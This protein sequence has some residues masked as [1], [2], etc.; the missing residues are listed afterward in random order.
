MVKKEKIENEKVAGI[1]T[2][3]LVG[4]IWY[5]ADEKMNKSN[6]VKFHTKQAINFF[7]IMIVTSLV[8][9]FIIWVPIIG[10]II[11]WAIQIAFLV[12]WIIGIINSVNF[13]K[14]EIPIIGSF[15]EKYLT[16]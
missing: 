6:F 13:T 14:K 7:I 1:L 2:Y 5:F 11:V 8:I 15:A 10:W 12:L 4:I 9:S 3:F 16:F